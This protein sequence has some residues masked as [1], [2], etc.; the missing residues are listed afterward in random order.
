MARNEIVQIINP[1]GGTKSF[2][3]DAAGNKLSES[4]FNGN[5]TVYEYDLYGNVV[6]MTDPLGNVT[7]YTYDSNQNLIKT[8][9][10]DGA[11]TTRTVAVSYTHLFFPAKQ[12]RSLRLF[13]CFTSLKEFCLPSLFSF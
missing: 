7:T 11:E 1:D 9:Y 13:W 2:T 6:K 5:V 8:T 4:D 3:Y 12:E 10:P